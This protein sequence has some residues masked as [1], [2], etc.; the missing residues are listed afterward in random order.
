MSDDE[1]QEGEAGVAP[2]ETGEATQAT[3]RPEQASP[4]EPS[5]EEPKPAG[6][7]YRAGTVAL[8]GRPN[9][10]K[11]TLMNQLLKEKVAIVSDKPQTTRHRLVGILS[12]DRG[13]M[14][15]H[16]TPGVHRPLHDL[17]RRMMQQALEA[18]NEADV[19]CLLVDAS[20]KPGAGETY[21]LELLEQAKRPKVV[22]LNKVDQMNKGKL[23]PRI[24]ELSASGL[25][26]EIVPVSALTGD[27]AD[28]LLD[29]LWSLLPEGEPLYDPELLTIH[30]ERYLAA[31]RIREKVLENTREELPF[32]TAVLIEGWE[33]EPSGGLTRI[34]ASILVE[35]PG[36]KRILVGHQ[37]SMIKKIG[38]AARLDLEEFLGRRVY[39]DLHVRHEPRWRESRRILTELERDLFTRLG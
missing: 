2:V 17:N 4:E 14:V 31:E 35:R 25:F 15:F 38:T 1:R 30:P 3:A 32:S 36:Q 11:S 5:L 16:D 12:T 22:A 29:I 6:T 10:G 19:I 39:L 27:G 21:V 33:D 28:V 8:V 24:E 18:L 13:Q 7:G 20:E 37:G 34:Y 9:A 26:Q 23:L